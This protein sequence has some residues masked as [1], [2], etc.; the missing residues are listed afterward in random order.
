MLSSREKTILD[1]INAEEANRFLQKLVQ[2]NSENPPGNEKETALL[3]AEKM[4]AGG[5]DVELQE[6]EKNR[7]YRCPHIIIP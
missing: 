6:V 1:N 3:I 5:F 2:T 4:S 7:E